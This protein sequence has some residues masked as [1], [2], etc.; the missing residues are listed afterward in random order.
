MVCQLQCDD[1]TEAT[2]LGFV[3]AYW[4]TVASVCFCHGC[5]THCARTGPRTDSSSA[6]PVGGHDT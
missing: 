5:F 2:V 6:R 3:V 1:G 4:L